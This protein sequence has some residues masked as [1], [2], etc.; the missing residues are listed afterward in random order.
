LIDRFLIE[1]TAATAASG[2]DLPVGVRDEVLGYTETLPCVGSE[3]NGVLRE[4][5]VVVAAEVP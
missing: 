2:E 3:E 4:V 5:V 1:V